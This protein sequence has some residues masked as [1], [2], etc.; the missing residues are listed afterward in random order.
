MKRLQ[1]SV[2]FTYITLTCGSLICAFALNCFLLPYKLT[3][4][5]YSGIASV[6]LYVFSLPVGVGMILLNIPTF[7]IAF[8]LLG[9]RI[10]VRSGYALLIFSAATELIPVRAL[11]GDMLMC[12]IY[13]GIIMGIG[14]GIN[15][16]FGGSTG[17]TDL[18]ALIIHHINPAFSVSGVLFAVDALVVLLTAVF[19]GINEA[20]YSLICVYIVIK[21]FGIITEGAKKA[22]VFVIISDKHPD[23]KRSVFDELDRGVTELSASGGYSGDDRPALLCTVEEGRQSALLKAL[24]ERIDENAFVISMD[25][26]EV[27]GRGFR[28]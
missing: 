13:G 4:G 20:L 12:A 8:K 25:A 14:L 26:R 19:A 21:C 15:I 18:L 23:I 28:K 11:L 24:V 3:M 17:G 10:C 1:N 5:G 2:P 16:L 9:K 22:R 27:I 7:I 6:F